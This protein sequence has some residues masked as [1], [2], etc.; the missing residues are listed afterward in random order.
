MTACVICGGEDR[1]PLW[2]KDGWS[3]ARCG[4]CGT[5]SLDP[6]PAADESRALYGEGYFQEGASGGYLDYAGDEAIHRHN[7]RA[8]CRLLASPEGG[9]L[10]DVGCAVGFF[11]D[12]ARRCG[13]RVE[14]VEVSP[15]AA[16]EARR[17][18]GA[19]IH[20]SLA[21]AG[22]AAEPFDAVTFFQVLEHMPRPAD[23]LGQA[24]ACLR[25]GGLVAIE[26]WD[27]DSLVA[28]LFGSHWQQV[29]PPSVIHLFSRRDVG[30]LLERTGFEVR[31]AART[32][33]R[34][35]IGFVA[36][37]LAGKYPRAGGWLLRRIEAAGYGRRAVSYRWGD[38]ITVT[39]VAS[40]ERDAPDPARSE[41][42]VVDL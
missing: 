25:P 1:S 2:S 12:E 16:A 8:R 28:R 6:Q 3:Y 23:A 11:L 34:V 35:S 10:L 37:L 30:A 4:G 42:D 18:T 7:A 20:D 24:R 13:W 33:K 14:G 40:P 21:A 5:V 29:T 15:W 39:G 22:S 27:R 36:G 26:T 31:S 32:S 17:R 38:L 19:P 9:R 41:V